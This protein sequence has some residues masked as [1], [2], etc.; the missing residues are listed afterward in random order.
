MVHATIIRVQPHAHKHAGPA[1]DLPVTIHAPIPAEI[2]ARVKHAG[3]PVHRRSAVIRLVCKEFKADNSLL[4]YGGSI[5]NNSFSFFSVFN[6]SVLTI[7][8]VFNVQIL[9]FFLK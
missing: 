5:H 9:I 6:A 2:P 4:Q 1:E 8:I 3:H 7:F